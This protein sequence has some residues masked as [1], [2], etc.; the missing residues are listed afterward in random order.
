MISLM[1]LCTHVACQP[2][3]YCVENCLDWKYLVVFVEASLNAV[4]FEWQLFRHA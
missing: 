3:H 4:V 1:L 2:P